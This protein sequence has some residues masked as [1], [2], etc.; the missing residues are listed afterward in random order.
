MDVATSGGGAPTSSSSRRLLAAP[1][2]GADSPSAAV[3]SRDKALHPLSGL[4]DFPDSARTLAPYRFFYRVKVDTV[5][6][7]AVW[8]GARLVDP[9]EDW[10]SG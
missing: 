10:V 8:H 5:W 2:I 9:P 1:R 4:R 6:I 3:A 7:A